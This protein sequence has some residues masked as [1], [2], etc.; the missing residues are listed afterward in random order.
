MK[1]IFMRKKKSNASFKKSLTKPSGYSRTA[2]QRR[3][4][5]IYLGLF[6]FLAVIIQ[7]TI[8]AFPLAGKKQNSQLAEFRTYLFSQETSLSQ[9]IELL[10]SAREGLPG[11]V[12]KEFKDSEWNIIRNQIQEYD[13]YIFILFRRAGVIDYIRNISQDID[14]QRNIGVM[15]SKKYSDVVNKIKKLDTVL[16]DNISCLADVKK[17]REKLMSGI[18]DEKLAV[19]T[20]VSSL[21]NMV[22]HVQGKDVVTRCA[23]GLD[24]VVGLTEEVIVIHDTYVKKFNKLSTEQE[25]WVNSLRTIFSISIFFIGAYARDY[26]T[27]ILN[28]KPRPSKVGWRL[29]FKLWGR[30]PVR[31]FR[32]SGRVDR[33]W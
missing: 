31:I 12:L 8:L 9:S 27:R 30:R 26:V 16:Q 7:A 1:R 5:K 11:V 20:K 25:F 13:A 4:N 29:R 28:P 10:R 19:E 15:D 33:W 32:K 18:L 3:L 23:G 22:N 14:N 17:D 21:I 24:S 2:E 6:I